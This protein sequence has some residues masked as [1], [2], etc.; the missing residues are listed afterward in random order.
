ML[1]AWL[2]ALCLL[3]SPAAPHAEVLQEELRD[4]LFSGNAGNRTERC[5]H[6]LEVQPMVRLAQV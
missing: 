1:R 2:D 3:Q 6:G 5:Y 4:P